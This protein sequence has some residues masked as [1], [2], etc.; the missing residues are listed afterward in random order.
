MNTYN[1]TNLNYLGISVTSPEYPLDVAGSAWIRPN[2][3]I[4]PNKRLLYDTGSVLGVDS[5]LY[6]TGDLQVAGNDIIDSGGVTR[7]TLGSSITLGGNLNLN[8][9][10]LTNALLGSNLNGNSYSIH[11]LDWL[12][13][14]NVNASNYVYGS[15]GLCIG[16]TC[17]SS[18][19]EVGGGD[20][21]DVLAG[22]GITVDN[23]GG[24]QPRVNL[25][26]SA[27]GDGLSYSAGV[28]SVGAGTCISVGSDSVGVTAGCIGSTQLSSDSNSLYNV[29]GKKMQISGSDVNV[30]EGN[31]FKVGGGFGSGGLTIDDK[32]NILTEGNLTYSGYTWIID[33]LRYNGTVEAPYGVKGGYLYPGRCNTGTDCMQT[34]YYL[35]NSDSYIVSNADFNVTSGKDVCISGGKCL[36][37]TGTGSGD[38]TDVLAGYGIT[39]DNSGGPQPRVNLSSS[40]AGDGLSYTAGVL[41]VNAGDPAISGLTI[42]GDVLKI[43]DD[44]CN[45]GDFFRSYGTDN[46][47]YCGGKITASDLTA[48]L[49]LGWGNLS[50]Y[51]PACSS[52][53]FVTQI[54]DTL[55]CSAPSISSAAGW[56]NTSTLVYLED[57]SDNVSINTLFV[58]NTNG[59]VGIGISSPLAKL[60][61]QGS[62]AGGLSLNV[63]DDLFVNDTSGRV[64]IGISSPKEKLH[65]NNGS[66]LID[67]PS[68]SYVGSYDTPDN[69]FG[70]YVSGKYAYVADD[71][72]GLVIVDVSNPSN[73]SYV[74]SYDTAGNANGVYVSGKY[75]Y[76]ADGTNG[77]VIVDV[78]GADIHAAKIGNIESNDITVTENM[79]IG[80]NLFIR[81]GLNVGPGGIKSDGPVSFLN[82]SLVVKENGRVGIGISSP[83]A[84]LE[85]VG[86]GAGGLSLSVTDDLFVNDT[87]GRVGIGTKNT[88]AKLTVYGNIS[89]G[90]GFVAANATLCW[91]STKSIG[92]CAGSISSSGICSDCRPIT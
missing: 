81:N 16:T 41:A 61:I 5:G 4:G 68:P 39:V 24:P 57:S 13:S 2:L 23:S 60:E 18:W 8:N 28:L 51:P 90:S 46:G 22:Y 43:Y 67:N 89:F 88:T 53:Q 85:I 86:S 48:D 10:Q 73:P 26:S 65:L 45:A 25:S 58:D 92:R 31:N 33:T 20:V 52:G 63:T 84:K 14:T 80:N 54:G 71:F 34:S 1:I 82:N 37:Q 47:W 79:D 42:S 70:V 40:A 12:N 7:I 76:V 62:G 38:V 17:K 21:T 9:N 77:L 29:T 75:A 49:G 3:Y 30:L 64:G 36:S 19:S 66:L 6:I 56:K 15:K 32:G 91:T 59:R 50:N 87:S 44:G 78:K 74:G 55:T 72:N 11:S 27:A 35:Y 69:A 83:L